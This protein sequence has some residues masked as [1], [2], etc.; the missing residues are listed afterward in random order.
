[1]RHSRGFTL[2]EVLVVLLI[3]SAFSGLVAFSLEGTRNRS[4][5]NEVER[6]RVVLEFAS[7]YAAVQG[8][9]VA[10]DLLAEGYR[11][12]AMQT[13]GTWKLLFAPSAL[14]AQN[15][16]ENV[17]VLGLSIDQVDARPPYRIVFGREAPEYV[18]SLKTPQGIETLS[19]S[20]VGSVARA[21]SEPRG[22]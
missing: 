20:L 11:F 16:P 18:L 6:L 17:S 15:W 5:E 22:S 12:S 1:M 9:P 19:G 14:A 21:Q 4:I 10:V 8:T 7:D 2:I 13:D 3:I